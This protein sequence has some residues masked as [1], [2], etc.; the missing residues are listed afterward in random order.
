MSKRSCVEKC[1][2]RLNHVT[3]LH[4]PLRAAL[5]SGTLQQAASAAAGTSEEQPA[6]HHFN[7]DHFWIGFYFF[8]ILA[9]TG[10]MG[11]SLASRLPFLEGKFIGKRTFLKELAY[12]FFLL[13]M[14]VFRFELLIVL[15]RPIAVWDG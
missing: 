11:C 5:R 3:S 8:N 7:D 9:L 6:T 13:N 4:T 10:E 2:D 1:P 14:A 12:F 15:S